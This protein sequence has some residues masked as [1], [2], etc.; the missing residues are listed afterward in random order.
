M[1]RPIGPNSEESKKSDGN[2]VGTGSVIIAIVLIAGLCLLL[3]TLNN[4]DDEAT[5]PA[6]TRVPA[7]PDIVYDVRDGEEYGTAATRGRTFRV[8]VPAAA[9]NGDMMRIAEYEA[10]QRK[11]SYKS[12]TFFMYVDR[13]PGDNNN[14]IA[15]HFY[16]W[17]SSTGRVRNCNGP[18]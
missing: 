11:E 18:C 1:N 13:E 6:A 17:S 15:D 5:R 16:E 4:R 3:T 7:K 10:S 9:S 12:L 2:V 8:V 14:W